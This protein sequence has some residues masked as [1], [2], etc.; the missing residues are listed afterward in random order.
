MAA[1]FAV[2]QGKQ[3]T[4]EFVWDFSA[5]DLG[6]QAAQ[7]LS[8]P[9]GAKLP[10][11]AIINDVVGVCEVPVVGASGTISLGTTNSAACFGA[12]SQAITG[13]DTVGKVIYQA[14]IP[15]TAVQ[16]IAAADRDVKMSIATANLTAGKVRFI[17]RGYVP[18]NYV[19]VAN[20]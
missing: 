17:F 13:L 11:G 14:V 12:A 5:G 15:T 10:S 19:Q 18:S 2:T 8:G 1:G 6:T 4:Q 20:D 7:A 16:A 3:F 9:N